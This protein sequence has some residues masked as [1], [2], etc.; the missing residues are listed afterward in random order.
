MRKLVDAVQP[1]AEQP[2][3]VGQ[4]ARPRDDDDCGRAESFERR[5]SG[6]DPPETTTGGDAEATGAEAAGGVG[7]DDPPG[8]SGGAGATTREVRRTAIARARGPVG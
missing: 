8:T 7:F 6:H 3:R 4:S 2:A 1:A 5:R